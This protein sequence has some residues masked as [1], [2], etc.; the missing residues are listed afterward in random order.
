MLPFENKNGDST[1]D[2][3]ADGMSD[4][5]RSA[6]NGLPGLSVKARSSSAQLRG[7]S[8][9]DAGAKLDVAAVLEGSL[10]RSGHRLR[11]TAELVRVSDENTLWSGSFDRQA[12]ELPAVQ[13]SIV[14]ARVNGEGDRHAGEDDRLVE[15][16]QFVGGHG[17]DVTPIT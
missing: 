16:D 1:Y 11:V 17:S 3:L 7:K 9:R 12:N 8:A 6:L 5:L 2:Y 13:D 14:R 4:E 10:S 15:S